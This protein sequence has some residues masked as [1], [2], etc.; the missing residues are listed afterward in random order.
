MARPECPASAAELVL[1]L[2]DLVHRASEA[3]AIA[4]W[5]VLALL[6]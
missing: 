2:A 3:A 6:E 5:P 1:A 4:A